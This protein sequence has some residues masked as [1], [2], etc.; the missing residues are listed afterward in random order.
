MRGRILAGPGR[1]DG[2]EDAAA[3]IR[4]TYDQRYLENDAFYL[5]NPGFEHCTSATATCAWKKI[6]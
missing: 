5:S 4:L 1:N 6:S 2:P 3:H